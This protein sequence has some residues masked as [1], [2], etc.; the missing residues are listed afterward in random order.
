M[1]FFRNEKM[2]KVRFHI[3]GKKIRKVWKI[4]K[5]REI[6]MEIMGVKTLR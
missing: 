6:N 1:K 4:E 2:R 3:F 5:L